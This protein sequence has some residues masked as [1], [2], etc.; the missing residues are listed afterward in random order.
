MTM[1]IERCLRMFKNAELEK[2]MN[3]KEEDH[4]VQEME[5]CN[6]ELNNRCM[7]RQNSGLSSVRALKIKHKGGGRLSRSNNRE[8]ILI[9]GACFDSP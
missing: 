3:S 2:N 6:R 7:A 9:T 4:V 5:Y 8:P 1:E